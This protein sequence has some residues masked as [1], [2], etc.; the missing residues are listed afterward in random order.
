MV[1]IGNF[2]KYL[3]VTSDIPK[4]AIIPFDGDTKLL[5]LKDPTPDG[6]TLITKF[7]STH[8]G[9][10]IEDTNVPT[11][12]GRV[13][14]GLNV[15]PQLDFH[16]MSGSALV[17]EAVR[18]LIEELEPYTHQFFP[19]EVTMGKTDVPYGM[20][21]KLMPCNRLD[22]MDRDNSFPI[23]ERGFYKC[24]FGKNATDKLQLDSDAI[25]S[26]HLWQ[27][28]YVTIGGGMWMSD[29]LV[30]AIRDA[31][32]TGILIHEPISET[33]DPA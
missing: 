3:G 13:G 15:Y 10:P 17:S 6:G 22:T 18:D 29:T 33:K 8:V 28:K 14:A 31:G 16:T 19:I 11:L 25:G 7:G 21:F 2:E 4:P 20:Y 32:L 24:G 23:N 30:E 27:E 5:R 9:R 26:H 12:A 1:Y